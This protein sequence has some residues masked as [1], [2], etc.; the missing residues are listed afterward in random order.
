MDFAAQLAAFRARTVDPGFAGL[1]VLGTE[2]HN[3]TAALLLG[4]LALRRVAFLLTPETTT[5]AEYIAGLLGRSSEGW[6]C[7]VANHLDTR[8]VYRSVKVLRER[9]DDIPDPARI[10]VDVT[11]G[12]KPMS[13]G[14]EKAAHVLGMTTIYVESEYYPAGG[15]KRGVIPGTQRLVVPPDPYT[16][17]GDL[18]AAEAR[19]LYAAHDY[20]GAGRMLTELATRVPEHSPY[21]LQAELAAA[22]AAWDA[23]DAPGALSHLA[24]V[25]SA[26]PPELPATA[27]ATLATQLAALRQLVDDSVHLRE[28][29]SPELAYLRDPAR[30]LPLLGSLHA[31]ALRR[32]AQRRFDVAALLHYRCLELLSQ[33]RLATYG[34]LTDAPRYDDVLRVR[35]GL[36]AAYERIER[37]LF[38]RSRPRGMPG[39]RDYAKITLFNGYMLLAALDDPLVAGRDIRQIRDRSEARNRSTLA[40]GFRSITATEYE[41]FRRLV[42]E[43]LDRFFDLYGQDRAAWEASYSFVALERLVG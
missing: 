23:F 20:E 37:A 1:I 13:V 12:R 19:R 27:R 2:Q 41:P 42:E 24:R 36:P 14:L 18:E 34:L 21:A 7:L 3:V 4:T 31:N 11:G 40:H 30:V 25:V 8:E 32:E 5:F 15:E 16:V 17:F 10:A 22:Y 43:L 26:E 33:I 29:R 38:P 28:Q 39:Y 35:P 6:E 9:W